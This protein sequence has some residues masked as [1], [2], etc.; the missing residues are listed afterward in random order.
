MAAAGCAALGWLGLYGYAWNDYDN[1]AR[2][3]VDEL[4]HGRFSQFV[5][6]APPYGGSLLERAP[7]ALLA[8]AWGG[9]E[10]AVYRMLAL[11]C[12][13]ASALLAVWLVA[14]MRAAGASRLARGVALGLCVATPVMLPALELG[15]PEEALGACLVIA[16]VL[17]AS[18][19]GT[20]PRPLLAGLVLGLA[21]ANKQWAVLAAGP[22]LLAL[23]P[24]LRLRCTAVAVAVAGAVLAPLL[25][26]SS[27]GYAAGVG[28]VAPRTSPIFQPWQAWWFFG[29]HGALVHGLFGTP[30][31]GYRVAAHWAGTIARPLVL[32]CGAVLSVA[33]WR[34]RGRLTEGEALLLLALL[35]LLRCVLDTWDVVYYTIPFLTALLVWEVRTRTERPPFIAL[36][37]GALAWASFE[38]LPHHVSP[39]AQAALF[40]CWSVPLAVW[41]AAQLRREPRAA[42][43]AR[44]PR[45][46]RAHPITVSSLGIRVS[47]SWPF[48]V[49]TTRSS[50][51]TPSSPGR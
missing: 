44:R 37:A 20:R 35:L 38:W 17:L 13:V 19:A 51:R 8:H 23:P 2:A 29:H 36:V 28:A 4:V 41:L 31:P 32:L 30:K 24:G 6:L 33:F 26:V 9:D 48:P 49:T 39:D 18:G 1:E 14:R 34:A 12:L 10:L 47:T 46:A 50:I 42:T 16:A 15:H 7:F 43:H 45:L 22:V 3:A 11:P 5:H 25:L 27:G 21:I 40:V